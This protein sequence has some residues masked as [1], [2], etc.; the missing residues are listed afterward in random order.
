[1][2]LR[3][4]G[5]SSPSSSSTLAN[6]HP[7][8]SPSSSLFKSSS[9]SSTSQRS[10]WV[11]RQR[12]HDRSTATFKKKLFLI[13]KNQFI[14]Y[15]NQTLKSILPHK[16][17]YILYPLSHNFNFKNYVIL[18][19]NFNIIVVIRWWIGWTNRS[20]NWS[21]YGSFTR[22]ITKSIAKPRASSI[23]KIYWSGKRGSRTTS[24]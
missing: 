18:L 11:K 13:K 12:S 14:S 23:E 22:R 5:V 20:V 21:Y 10:R 19:V 15:I 6:P 7:A 4:D 2:V 3:L 1:M 16:L 9:P 24:L 8:S 17:F